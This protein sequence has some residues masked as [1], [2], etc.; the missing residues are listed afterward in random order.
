MTSAPYPTA[1]AKSAT[2]VA[3]AMPSGS[4]VAGNGTVPFTGG[5]ATLVGSITGVFG[6][7]LAVIAAL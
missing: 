3:S 7:V 6:A 1:T 5:A 2:T 4:G